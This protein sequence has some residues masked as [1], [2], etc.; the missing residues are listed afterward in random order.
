MKKIIPTVII[1]IVATGIFA[2]HKKTPFQ[3]KKPDVVI[4][5]QAM[6]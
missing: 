1:A 5:K 4:A 3:N 6:S 2:Q